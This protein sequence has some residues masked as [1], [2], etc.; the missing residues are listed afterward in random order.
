MIIL[1]VIISIFEIDKAYAVA[2]NYKLT[3]KSVK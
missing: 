2:H 3:V 1:I